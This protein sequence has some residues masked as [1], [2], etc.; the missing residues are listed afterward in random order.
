MPGSRFIAGRQQ[1]KHGVLAYHRSEASANR[2]PALLMLHGL[3]DSGMCW[4][5][6]AE[7]LADQFDLILLD[8]PGH[9]G[10][11]MPGPQRDP[12]AL[13][14]LDELL[15]GL[16]LDRVVLLGHSVGAL[17]AGTMAA[18]CPDRVER[19]VLE[20][21]PL[22]NHP[23]EATPEMVAAFHEQISAI[24]SL[25]LA[26]AM[27]FGQRQHPRWPTEEF[28]EWARAKQQVNPDILGCYRFPRWGGWVP[29]VQAL[30]LLIYG[31]SGSD[32]VVSD[33]R[34]NEVVSANPNF[35]AVSIPGAGHNVRRE[36]F[37]EYRR[38]LSAFLDQPMEQHHERAAKR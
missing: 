37:T 34:V 26:E 4:F 16:G 15:D 2:R 18:A 8:S 5:R 33:K 13:I 12:A 28:E 6:T 21:P 29:R 7:S 20:D 38:V 11:S 1:L 19:L 9:G 30:S 31:E 23:F 36:N 3:G 10:S 25:S 35:R 14:D 22:R 17:L 24:A 27:A 32:S